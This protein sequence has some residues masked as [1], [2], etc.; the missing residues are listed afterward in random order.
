MDATVDFGS[1]KSPH[2]R[3]INSYH[4]HSRQTDTQLGK[5][6]R[7]SGAHP[8]RDSLVGPRL[9]AGSWRMYK[10]SNRRRSKFEAEAAAATPVGPN[11]KWVTN[12]KFVGR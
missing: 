9:I 11:P 6:K 3:I 8:I 7:A 1:G 12:K 2:R 10:R 5:A 4:H